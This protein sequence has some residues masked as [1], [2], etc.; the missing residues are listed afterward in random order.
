MVCEFG[1]CLRPSVLFEI[2]MRTAQ[3][4]PPGGEAADDQ[5]R[6]GRRRQPD[7]DVESLVDHVDGALAHRQIDLHFGIGGEKFGDDG[8]NVLH[9]MGGGIDAQ[10]AARRRL[11]GAGDVVGLFDVGK[12]LNA[13]VVIGLADLGEADLARGALKQPRAEPVF[14]RLDMVAHHRRRHVEPAAGG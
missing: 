3:H 14:E 9:D 8:R 1:Q 5:A 7:R 6:I 12:D 10:R 2:A 4:V 13:A 11:L